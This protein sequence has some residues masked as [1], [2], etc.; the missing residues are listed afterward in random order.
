M[1]DQEAG[2][3]RLTDEQITEIY[4]TEVL[5]ALDRISPQKAARA[6][7]L[8]GP[9]GSRKTSL[10]SLV[11]EQLGLG[12][13]VVYLDGDDLLV[14]HPDYDDLAVQ[15]GAPEA[16]RL[17]RLDMGVLRELLLD[18]VRSRRLTIML[19]GPFTDAQY[20]ADR[21]TE[22]RD[23]GY[24]PELAYTALHPALSQLATMNR[25][26]DALTNGPGYSFLV[27][28]ALLESVIRNA[29]KTMARIERD[30]LA[31]ALHVVDAAGVA[32]TKR[33]GGDGT[34]R[35]ERSAAEVIIATR[36]QVWPPPLK[37]DFLR[38]RARADS[39]PLGED[40]VRWAGRL[41][42]VDQLASPMLAPSFGGG[43][44]SMA[45][46]ARSRST[47]VLRPAGAAATRSKAP[48][49]GRRPSPPEA[50]GQER[51][52]GRSR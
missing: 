44:R 46:V 43:A 16:A 49:A 42:R 4:R 1:S 3:R 23:A 18:E 22:F 12:E 33:L 8:G 34:W 28:P 26:I 32:F 41:D 17:T 9:Q 24:S 25:H 47:T 48:Q 29:P 21:L 15:H 11:A 38:W 31:D 19:V 37:E 45:R 10:R 6:V 39:P 7:I 30:R 40:P 51:G 27:R 50:P 20:T 52:T 2:A 36:A 35:P 5:P 13:D 14:L